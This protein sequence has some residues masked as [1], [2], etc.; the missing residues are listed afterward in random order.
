MKQVPPDAEA[1]SPPPQ[2]PAAAAAAPTVSTT[3]LQVWSEKARGV[4][5]QHVPPRRVLVEALVDGLFACLGIALLAGIHEV[6]MR[7]NLSQL[8][9]SF[10]ATAVLI[11]AAPMS[12]LAQPRHVIGGHLIAAVI[13]VC[14]AKA[15]DGK[16]K[17]LACGL[18]VGLAVTATGLTGTTHPPAGATALIAVLT[19]A[20]WVY[21]GMP[22]G[23][24]SCIMVLTALLFNNLHRGRRYPLY[25]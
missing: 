7:R 14:V 8:V 15:F 10:G 5:Q 17:W 11:F 2:E 3:Y 6:A 23:T 24:G 13:G 25:W 22:I 4:G 19:D 20:D 9:A 12:P 1:A 21:I 18:S 16:V